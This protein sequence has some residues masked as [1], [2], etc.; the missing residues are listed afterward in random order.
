[1]AAIVPLSVWWGLDTAIEA[2]G[3]SASSLDSKGSA[4]GTYSKGSAGGKSRGDDSKSSAPV[5]ATVGIS[6]GW[7]HLQVA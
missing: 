4:G 6:G 7:L 2:E 5:P 1:M 3:T